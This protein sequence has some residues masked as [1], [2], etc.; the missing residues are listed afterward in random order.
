[1]K[2]A[3]IVYNIICSK[4]VP[5]M[6][7][8]WGGRSLLS[9]VGYV[10]ISTVMREQ[11]GIMGGELSAHYSF[12]DNAF[13]DSGFIAFVILLQLLSEHEK[14]LSETTKP[15]Y[16]YFKSAELNFEIEDKELVMERVKEKYSDGKQDFSFTLSI[17]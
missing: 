12:R 11:K 4:I 1:E 2:G 9:K 14:T 16:K 7:K 10:N 15:F 5:E 3:G 6:I 13:A 17:T 8:E